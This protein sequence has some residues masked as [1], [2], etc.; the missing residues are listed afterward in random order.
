MN[1]RLSCEKGRAVSE[2]VGFAVVFGIVV[3]S[4]AL[5]YTFGVGALS[6]V[7]RGE[8]FD[9]AGRAFDILA[10][11]MEDIHRNGAPG[12]STELE[13]EGG[14]LATTGRTVLTVN[15]NQTRSKSFAASPISYTRGDEGLHYATGAVIRTNRDSAAM[16]NDPPFR[17]SNASTKRMVISFIETKPVG[18]TSS[19]AGGTVRVEGRSGGTKIE[20]NETKSLKVNVSV[21]SPRHEA[22][23]RYFDRQKLKPQFC[24]TD[25]TNN[26]VVCGYEVDELYVRRTLIRV[27]LTQ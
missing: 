10:D 13:F 26:T 3:L 22:W 20:V 27:R 1:G 15:T 24:D 6:E 18:N 12:R 5:V 9:N 4:I 19:I 23:H 25:A 7:Q 21:T 2:V 16:L 17:F 14:E 8:A 11:N